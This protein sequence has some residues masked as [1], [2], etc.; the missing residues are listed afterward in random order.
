[1]GR[2][3]EAKQL[4]LGIVK[5]PR[6]Q[7]VRVPIIGPLV[8]PLLGLNQQPTTP[9]ALTQQVLTQTVGIDVLRLLR[10]NCGDLGQGTLRLATL[11]ILTR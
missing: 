6:Q 3:L 7:V 4:G 1:L 11:D 9:T 10:Q 8:H 5:D 2:A